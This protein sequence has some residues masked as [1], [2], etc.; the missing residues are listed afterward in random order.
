MLGCSLG[1][2]VCTAEGYT[3]DARC[4]IRL[5]VNGSCGSLESVTETRA[6][7]WPL[8]GCWA[9][10]SH[11]TTVPC[12]LPLYHSPPSPIPCNVLPDWLESSNTGDVTVT[13]FRGYDI[14]RRF[15]SP[16]CNEANISFHPKSATFFYILSL[17]Q[18]LNAAFQLLTFRWVQS[19]SC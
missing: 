12:S 2:E 5:R 15:I 4:I 17:T 16:I 11:F 6:W 3:F 14:R 10:A 7:R 9:T 8:L 13:T 19:D 1:T 18:T